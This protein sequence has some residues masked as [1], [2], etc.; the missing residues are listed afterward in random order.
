MK[1]TPCSNIVVE[2]LLAI[3]EPIVLMLGTQRHGNEQPKHLPGYTEGQR[4]LTLRFISPSRTVFFELLTP[5]G[6][7]SYSETSHQSQ[8]DFT[9]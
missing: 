9:T 2:L 4:L 1:Q 7:G 6:P 5:E 3:G 8:T